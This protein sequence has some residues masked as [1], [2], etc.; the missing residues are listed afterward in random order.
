V[1]CDG[2]EEEEEEEK[3]AAVGPRVRHRQW[4]LLEVVLE[5]RLGWCDGE[6]EEEEEF[7]LSLGR[8]VKLLRQGMV[9]MPGPGMGRVVALQGIVVV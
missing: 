3:D 8:R 4:G 1:G 5:L 7:G 9:R 6:E 2:V